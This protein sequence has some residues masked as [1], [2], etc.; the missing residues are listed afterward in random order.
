MFAVLI[1]G[2]VYLGTVIV[3]YS[4]R[5]PLFDKRKKSIE[6]QDNEYDIA[7]NKSSSSQSNDRHIC[8]G[9]ERVSNS[10]DPFADLIAKYGQLPESS[11][12]T[13]TAS[14]N[15]PCS[16]EKQLVS[17]SFHRLFLRLW[18]YGVVAIVSLLFGVM[19]SYIF[20]QARVLSLR[21]EIDELKSKEAAGVME[22]MEG[23]IVAYHEGK[24]SGYRDGYE[25]AKEEFD[26]QY[27]VGYNFAMESA[28]SSARLYREAV[29]AAIFYNDKQTLS[30]L[31][32]LDLRGYLTGY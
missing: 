21:D 26:E 6:T 23:K 25:A 17:H 32:T 24:D 2:A 29:Q 3:Y 19:V 12:S 5:E 8:V 30:Y 1:A 16:K 11:K 20:M 27:E 31:M 7:A 13:N 15:R 9:V 22:I 10:G 28:I 14:A 4:K 18:K